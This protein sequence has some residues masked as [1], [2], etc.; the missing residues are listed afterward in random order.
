M[1]SPGRE[2]W[3][4]KGCV[5][6]ERRRPGTKIVWGSGVHT[7]LK[8]SDLPEVSG[9]KVE[10]PYSTPPQFLL[11]PWAAL[12]LSKDLDA[13]RHAPTHR[14]EQ[15]VSTLSVAKTCSP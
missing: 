12:H 1:K 14:C 9:M 10:D 2:P 4:E 8:G 5:L 13:L 11:L 6:I 15:V 3:E 7:I